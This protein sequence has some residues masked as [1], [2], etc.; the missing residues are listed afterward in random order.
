M[1]KKKYQPN[2]ISSLRRK[3]VAFC[4]ENG[5][6]F[7]VSNP[8]NRELVQQVCLLKN[9]EPPAAIKKE[10]IDFLHPLFSDV[11]YKCKPKSARI[12]SPSFYE[13][14]EWRELRYQVLVKHKGKCLCCGRSYAEHGVVIHVDHIKP[15]S[16]YPKLVLE[17]SNLQILCEDCNMGKSNK[18]ETDWREP[19]KRVGRKIRNT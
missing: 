7:S 5:I 15:K 14:P 19:I 13:M 10:A 6:V 4:K 8:S 9:I 3:A 1:K 17:I 18:D 11:V 2:T 16:K 12:P